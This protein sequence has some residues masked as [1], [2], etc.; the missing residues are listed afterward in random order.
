MWI[1]FGLIPPD[2]PTDGGEHMSDVSQWSRRGVLSCLAASAC[3]ATIPGCGGEASK[4]GAPE[5]QKS[6]ESMADFMKTQQQKKKRR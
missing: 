4:G 2:H 6:N 3:L 1:L 5:A